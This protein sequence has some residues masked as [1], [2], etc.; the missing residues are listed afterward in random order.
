[1]ELLQAG[2]PVGRDFEMR[3]ANVPGGCTHK[4]CFAESQ[5]LHE[6]FI[7]AHGGLLFMS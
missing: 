1:M 6:Y 3:V 2:M 7:S 4:P 5:N